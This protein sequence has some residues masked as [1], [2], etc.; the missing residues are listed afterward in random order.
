MK[1]TVTCKSHTPCRLIA[2]VLAVVLTLSVGGLGTVYAYNYGQ[3]NSGTNVIPKLSKQDIALLLKDT[4]FKM[5]SS[6]WDV[7]PTY[8]PYSAGKVRAAMQQK[9]TDR[10]NAMRALA[11]LPPVSLNS[12]LSELAQHGAV[13][14]A[15]QG[16]VTKTPTQPSDM[17]DAFYNKGLDALREANMSTNSQFGL[18][19]NEWM[20][21]S[22]DSTFTLEQRLRQLNPNM[23]RVG[24]GYAEKSTTSWW[25]F[26]EFSTAVFSNKSSVAPGYDFISWPASGYFPNDIFYGD[27]PWSISLNPTKFSV[28]AQSNIQVFLTRVADNK[29]WVFY[30]GVQSAGLGFKVNPGTPNTD[31]TIVFRPDGVTAYN[32]VYEVRVTGLYDYQGHQ[33]DLNF[34]V[35]FFNAE[36]Y[37]KVPESAKPTPTP[38]QPP[39]PWETLPPRDPNTDPSITQNPGTQNK[40]KPTLP[41]LPWYPVDIKYTDVSVGHWAYANIQKATQHGIMN[42][43]GN[44]RF[45]P[46]RSVTGYEFA[47]IL[48]RAFYSQEMA[49]VADTSPWTLKI[50]IV[51]NTCGIWSGLS[52]MNRH[53]PVTRYQM[54]TMIVNATNGTTMHR[55]SAKNYP[56][57]TSKFT[58]WNAVPQGYRDDVATCVYYGILDGVGGGKFDGA[59]YMDRAQAATVYCRLYNVL[60]KY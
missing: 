15:T 36:E 17:E 58:D 33:T 13:L 55:I 46:N 26:K 28:P 40:P 31:P 6:P 3:S 10:L 24:F 2:V 8:S 16:L 4:S 38:T 23:D 27:T 47:A 59:S 57:L 52:N 30:D 20:S 37:L 43:V 39:N 1:S 48:L 19:V 9:A 12:D 11:G 22:A 49:K 60:S 53:Q 25:L 29:A 44:S 5:Q 35:E 34:R 41:N 45:D 56:G 14:L 50:D 18:T 21:D 42:G 54:A 7:C 51:G 32:G